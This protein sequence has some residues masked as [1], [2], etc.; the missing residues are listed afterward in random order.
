RSPGVDAAVLDPVTGSLRFGDGESGRVPGPGDRMVAAYATTAG[1][2][3][4]VPAGATWTMPGVSAA[5]PLPAAGGTAGETLGAAARRAGD[6]LWAHERLLELVLPIGTLDGSDAAAV[7]ARRPPSRATTLADFERIALATPGTRIARVRAWAGV[8]AR[9]T[10]AAAPG[11][12]T[13][14]VVPSL[15][16]ARPAPSPGLLR[17]VRRRL[18]RAKTLGTRVR[19]TG[20]A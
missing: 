4:N 6:A 9:L 17:A 7:V 8:D 20:P 12:V 3:G 19:V 16:R 14:V 18:E 1:D 10:C 2:G 15:P 13:V 5:N 11:T